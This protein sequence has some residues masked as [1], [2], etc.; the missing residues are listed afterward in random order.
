MIIKNGYE[1]SLTANSLELRDLATGRSAY[2]RIRT[3][4]DGQQYVGGR[5]QGLAPL[6]SA[7]PIIASVVDPTANEPKVPLAALLSAL[8]DERPSRGAPAFPVPDLHLI[9]QL[10][11]GRP[12]GFRLGD[13][14]A[15][16]MVAVALAWRNGTARDFELDE[17]LVQVLGRGTDA[18]SA[19]WAALARSGRNIEREGRG[20]GS[21]WSM[22]RV[23]TIPD[24]MAGSRSRKR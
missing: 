23:W 10:A 6:A 3:D 14:T 11:S 13:D 16:S 20:P 2:F 4:V 1:R 24:W 12:T 7:I 21:V 8:D 18:E 9:R 15:V 5:G 22:P 19:K 17:D